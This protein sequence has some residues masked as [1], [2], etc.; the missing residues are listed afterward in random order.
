MSESFNGAVIIETL[1]V[2]QLLIIPLPFRQ[3][4][5]LSVK[6]LNFVNLLGDKL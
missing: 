4:T 1:P 5:G 6:T 3:S 2:A